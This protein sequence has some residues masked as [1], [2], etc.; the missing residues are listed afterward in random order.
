MKANEIIRL[1]DPKKTVRAEVREVVKDIKGRPHLL[2]RIRLSGW[3]FPERAE[4]PFMV[5]GEAVSDRVE[6]STDGH[7]ANAYF[8]ESL[9]RAERI[10]FG[11][12]KTVTWDFDVP[13]DPERML[14]LD[15]VRLPKGVVDQLGRP[16][17]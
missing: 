1:P 6:I 13:I 2:A 4:E 7:I 8:S 11:Y 5:V 14:R 15:R 17:D 12:G 3:H 10:S 16:E 9:P